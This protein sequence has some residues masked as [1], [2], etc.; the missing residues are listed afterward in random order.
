[1]CV[2]CVIIV[3]GYIVCACIVGIFR[4][5]FWKFD[6]WVDVIVDD[7]LP[8]VNGQLIFAH[9]KDQP[10]EFWI[11]LFEKAYAKYEYTSLNKLEL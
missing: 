7:F 5:S 8:T 11:A 3:T 10:N 1:M 2:F 9:N 6:V 4:F